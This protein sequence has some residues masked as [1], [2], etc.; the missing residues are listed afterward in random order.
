MA[1]CPFRGRGSVSTPAFAEFLFILFFVKNLSGDHFFLGG[2][3]SRLPVANIRPFGPFADRKDIP[4]RHSAVQRHPVCSLQAV[5]ALPGASC[6][7]FFSSKAFALNF[8]QERSV[9]TPA[10]AEFL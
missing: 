2:G 6:A 9:S 8:L 5:Y 7:G 4:H 10:F 3:G 1:V